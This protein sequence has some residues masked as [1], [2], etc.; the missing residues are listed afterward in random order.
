[1]AQTKEKVTQMLNGLASASMYRA[2][3][4]VECLP[5]IL[6]EDE[7]LKGITSGLHD[8]KKWLIV[9][10]NK[11]LLFLD[12]G[13]MGAL[14][15]LELPFR[16][17]SSVAFK[18]GLLMG[19]LEIGTSAKTFKI[20]GVIKT[21]VQPVAGVITELIEVHQSGSQSLPVH[22]VSTSDDVAGQLTKLA[23]LKNAGVLSDEEYAAAKKKVLGL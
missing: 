23:D 4:E 6:H 14:K 7:L 8:G 3:R 22:T 18:A 5:D 15:Q 13:M 21:D 12:K 17:I 19:D 11:R 10:T 1:M 16:Q 9:V 2:R 20:T